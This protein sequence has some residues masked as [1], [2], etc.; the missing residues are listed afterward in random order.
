M[1][2]AL[3]MRVTRFL[4]YQI[5]SFALPPCFFE[6]VEDV[7]SGCGQSFSVIVVSKV[8]EGKPLLQR[9]RCVG[10][11]VCEYDWWHVHMWEQQWAVK[12]TQLRT[13]RIAV[14]VCMGGKGRGRR[15][16]IELQL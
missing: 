13:T 16:G 12:S 5:S 14:D 3:S 8:F 4:V 7:S 11:H 10:E 2:Y 9:H 1:Y 6:E 15:C